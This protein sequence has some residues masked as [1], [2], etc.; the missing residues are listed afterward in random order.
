MTSPSPDRRR[1]SPAGGGV[2]IAL[3][4]IGGAVVG[5]L[6]RQPSIGLVAGLAVGLLLAIFVWLVDRRRG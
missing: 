6:Y 4:A 3:G 2:L 5:T 1:R